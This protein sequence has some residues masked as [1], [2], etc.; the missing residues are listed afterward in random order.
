[1]NALVVFIIDS[2]VIFAHQIAVA[3]WQWFLIS[4]AYLLLGLCELFIFLY[5][6]VIYYTVFRPRV[7]F[8][9]INQI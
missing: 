2:V 4:V 6:T 8:I 5:E 7:A 3:F 9:V 1:M